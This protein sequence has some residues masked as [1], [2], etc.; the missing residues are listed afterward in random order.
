M[1]DLRLAARGVRLPVALRIAVIYLAARAVTTLLFLLAAQVGAS[2]RHGEPATLA[3][4]SM[5]WDAQWYWVVGTGGYP[6][7]LPRTADG[8]V[9]QN[10]WAFLPV[11]PAL[12][13]MV[14]VATG[15]YPVAAIVVSFVAGYLACLALHALLRSGLD[16]VAATWAVVF[17]TAGP[18]AA[19]AQVGYAETLFLLWLFLALVCV[20][21]RRYGPLY[22]LVPLLGYTRPGVLAF[23][24]LLALHGALLWRRRRD[25]ILGA[26]EVVHIVLLGLMAAAVGLSWPL[27]AGAV[28][29][30]PG[31]YLETE[32]S[33]R[34]IWLPEAGD[35]F[36]PFEGVLQGAAMWARLC[37]VPEVIGPLVLIALVGLVAWALAFEPHVRRL[38]AEVRL[39]SAAY[40]LYLLAVVFPQSSVFRLL[41]PL[42]P[43]TGA[44]AAPRSTA[45]RV[46]VLA[47][48]L[49]GQWWWI[50]QMYG[51]GQT[52]WQVP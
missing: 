4:M 11:Y 2:A 46:G 31:A 10:A 47:A 1:V 49:A 21:R 43:L 14:S 20:Q 3:S 9:T 41:V 29:G 51:L 12:C 40:L 38:G 7:E 39:W 32:L 30:V 33:W 13:R 35:G 15:S 36:V 28:T 5:A 25:A 22:L 37:G 8:Q 52:A 44:L 42:T 45:W 18:L 23:A 48:G 17:F 16:D 27:I 34:R 24:L 6:A 19:L 26:R 50:L